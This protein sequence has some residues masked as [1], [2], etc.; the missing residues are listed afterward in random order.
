M[1]KKAF[2]SE[3]VRDTAKD[4]C[5]LQR[6][7]RLQIS[8]VKNIS[9]VFELSGVVFRLVPLYDGL[10]VDLYDMTVAV[11]KLCKRELSQ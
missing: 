1:Q 5:V 8:R 11:I 6:Q 10:L 7:R 2:N 4:K 9:R 3:M